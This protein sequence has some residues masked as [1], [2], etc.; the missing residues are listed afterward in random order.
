MH[1]KLDPSLGFTS[2]SYTHSNNVKQVHN[3]LTQL[4][5]EKLRHQVTLK[6]FSTNNVYPTF[7]LM[8]VLLMM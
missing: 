8:K 3:N 6:E 5:I 4:N 2:I 7:G 1:F